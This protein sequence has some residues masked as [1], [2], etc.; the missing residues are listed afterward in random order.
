MNQKEIAFVKTVWD[1][2]DTSGRHDLP[3][4][5][6]TDPY[7][8]LVSELMLQQTQ[9]TRV[10]SKYAAFMVAYP[11]VHTLATTGL[12]GVLRLWQGLGYNRRAK[13]L[14]QCAQEIVDKYDGVFPKDEHQLQ[15]LPGIGPYTAAAICAFA[16]NQP[17]ELI[18]T[19]VRQVYIHHF[20]TK[21]AQVTD[22]EI[23]HKVART[24]PVDRARAWYAAVM[25][26]GT[27]LKAT[28]GNN[29]RKRKGYL[30]QS[31]F[32]GSDRQIR[33]AILRA[34][35]SGR[36]DVQAFE[37]EL[38]TFASDRVQRQTAALLAEGLVVKGR[39]YYQLP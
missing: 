7:A 32:K 5:Q 30:K 21:A 12:G 34:L 11:T 24:M 20:F 6:T 8:I 37:A 28:H 13:F 3:W 4:R 2:Y 10:V 26:Y 29:T 22:Q 39:Q 38:S 19:N 23:L 33:G 27:Y 16:Y 15:A 17:V 18:E 9:V 36:L 25:D 35:Q 14:W 31:A 1:F